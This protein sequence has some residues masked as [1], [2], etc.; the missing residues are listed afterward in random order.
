MPPSG[1]LLDAS[2]YQPPTTVANTR[3]GALTAVDANVGDLFVFT[4]V[5]GAD[6]GRF[7]I[8]D[9]N[10]L[11]LTAV[12]TVGTS[13]AVTLRVTDASGAFLDQLFSIH[14]GLRVVPFCVSSS[15][16][17]CCNSFHPSF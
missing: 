9:T 12:G 11:V 6:A 13:F 14:D 1:L 3:V 10:V 7:D 15:Y 5:G 17:R 8:I 4:I 16:L 2:T